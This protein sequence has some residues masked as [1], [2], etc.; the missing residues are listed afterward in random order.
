[1]RQGVLASPSGSWRRPEESGRERRT[2]RGALGALTSLIG[3][4]AQ[5]APSESTVPARAPCVLDLFAQAATAAPSA[6]ALRV[7]QRE[8]SHGALARAA[9]ALAGRL[10]SAGVGPETPVGVCLERSIDHVVAMLGALRAGGAFLPLDPSWP[11]ER[12]RRVLDDAGA[13]AVVA[14]PVLCDALAD[15]R[16]TVLGGHLDGG[17]GASIPPWPRP[18]PDQLAYVIYTSGSTGEPKGVEITHGALAN[19]IA[20]HRRA[21]GLAP[22]DRV[23]WVAG[24][25]FDA[26]I[27][28]L[29]PAL[30]AGASVHAPPEGVR[31][32]AG[33]LRTWLVEE[34]I[35]LAYAP[36]PLAEAMIAADWPD[37]TALRVLLT[38]GDT[39][40]ARPRAG[41]PFR[42]VNNYGP[43][44]CTV[45][46]TSGDVAADGAHLPT[47]G[48]PIDQTRVHIVDGSGAAVREGEIGEILIAGAGLGRG[49]R[50]RLDLT[51]ERFVT[52]PALGERCYRTGDLGSWT[53][54]G[55]IAF[56]G[57]NDDQIQHLGHRIEPDEISA[58]LVRHPS[59]A[60][61][62][63]VSEGEGSAARLVAYVVPA[64]QAAPRAADLREFLSRSL[65][66]YMLPAQFARLTSLPLTANGKLDRKAL[67]SPSEVN[68]LPSAPYRAPNTPVERR[69]AAIVEALLDIDGVGLHD[70]FFLL[71]GHSLL[72]TQLLIRLQDAFGA[73]LALRDLFEAQTI[74]N[75]ARKVASSVEAMV[76]SMSEEEL[77]QRLATLGA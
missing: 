9:E 74:Q 30:A 3:A 16:R 36:T 71:G 1:M 26:S 8:I 67:P 29:A 59:V 5:P 38:G 33:E 73:E 48:R 52:L 64:A 14:T 69:T 32:A 47:I 61:C 57:R 43:T 10:A 28:E 27:W 65:P 72:G 44:E 13:P 35:T 66:R 41:L 56:H 51:D 34:A 40:H 12:L 70:N 54:A 31:A 58:A 50:G 2:V 25:G 24:L 45:V 68:A 76:A 46:A 17:P 75:L 49:Y 77:Q 6:L 62:A 21:F 53:A 23:G 19:L 55:E 37:G 20:W 18:R 4:R 11:V 42:V 22:A 15:S 63:V 39:L 7:G 60:Q